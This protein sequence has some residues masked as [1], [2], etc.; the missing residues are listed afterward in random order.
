MFSLVRCAERTIILPANLRVRSQRTNSSPFIRCMEWSVIMTSKGFA[1]APILMS[2]IQPSD[3]L[4]TCAPGPPNRSASSCVT[5]GSSS[6]VKMR[7]RPF[8]DSGTEKQ[9]ADHIGDSM[10]IWVGA[11]LPISNQMS[12]VQACVLECG[13]ALLLFVTRPHAKRRS[14]AAFQKPACK[15]LRSRTRRVENEAT[16]NLVEAA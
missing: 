14:S 15:V 4:V 13:S 6:T 5:D 11:E 16:T 7:K 9:N 12:I 10:G 1:A 3:A 2:A 8:M